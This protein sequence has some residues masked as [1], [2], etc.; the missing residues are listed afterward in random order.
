R[1][2]GWAVGPGGGEGWRLGGGGG[3]VGRR[4]RPVGG[5][6]RRR[7]PALGRVLD[8]GERGCLPLG[9]AG[10]CLA[11]GGRVG[12]GTLVELLDRRWW[13]H[14]E[15]RGVGPVGVGVHGGRHLVG[16]LA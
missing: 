2:G 9:G 7:L 6:G 3:L 4:G 8:L 11:G 10:R 14:V 1:R 12:V 15:V 5:R 16:A 13:G